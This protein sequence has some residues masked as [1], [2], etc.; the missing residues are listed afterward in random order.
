M[1]DITVEQFVQEHN[2]RVGKTQESRN[3]GFDL[4][5]CPFCASVVNE[6]YDPIEE[7]TAHDADC[8]FSEYRLLHQDLLAAWNKRPIEE[9]LRKRIAELESMTM[10]EFAILKHRKQYGDNP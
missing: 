3:R 9:A 5:D 2:D 1:T 6:C 8:P 4:V 7:Q 10:D